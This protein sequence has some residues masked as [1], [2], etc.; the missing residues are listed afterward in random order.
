MKFFTALFVPFFAIAGISIQTAPAYAGDYANVEIYGFSDEGFRFAFEQFGLE[1]GSGA[2]YSDIFVIDT[3]TDS[4]VQGSPFRL[5]KEA[6]EF[7]D[8]AQDLYDLRQENQ[9]AARETLA[10][11]RISGEGRTVGHNPPTEIGANPHKMAVN[12]RLIVP[13]A[14]NPMVFMLEEYPLQ[15]GDCAAYGDDVKGFRLTV[16]NEGIDRVINEDKKLPK[17]RGCPIRYRVER[18]V[19]FYPAGRPAV[20]AALILMESYG[21]E[22]PDGRFLAITGRI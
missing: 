22:G 19:T 5:K 3:Q 21:F 4:W 18:V 10:N 11:S 16:S 8:P 1:S 20:F 13:P 14:D 2:P 15:S 7:P 12:P 9:Q 17:S 6:D